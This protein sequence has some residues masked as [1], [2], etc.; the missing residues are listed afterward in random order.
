MQSLIM[1]LYT[2][3]GSS[4]TS[5]GHGAAACDALCGL[6]ELC[7]ASAD[8]QIRALAF[9]YSMWTQIFDIYVTKSENHKSKPMRHLLSTLSKLIS[10]HPD[11]AG[12]ASLIQY[13]VSVALLTLD[14]DHESSS[15]KAAVQTIEH[16]VA[17]NIINSRQ[18]LSV[19]D[20]KK[21]SG[22]TRVT[23]ANLRWGRLSGTSE[24]VILTDDFVSS[25]LQWVQY[26]D[27][28]PSAGRL[29]STFFNSLQKNLA[30][31]EP[32]DSIGQEVPLW[33]HPIKRALDE[34]SEL[35]DGLEKHVLPGLL[36]LSSA[37][38][39]AF[40]ATLPL[41]DL[42][43]GIIGLHTVGDIQLCLLT[44]RTMVEFDSSHGFRMCTRSF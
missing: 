32:E 6:L 2:T 10:E 25:I 43:E 26:P 5:L 28:A 7:K 40:L 3:L 9:D 19:L 36:R 20:E 18:L 13:A 35:L 42:Q 12:R 21:E 34:Q 8:S 38:T 39:Q 14:G 37:D 11:E 1:A 17:K 44:V 33:F 22:F 29:I 41:K 4:N 27:V 15:I 16:F 24:C 31:R 30:E 23:V